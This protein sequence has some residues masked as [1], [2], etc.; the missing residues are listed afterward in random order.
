MPAKCISSIPMTGSMQASKQG[1]EADDDSS[2]PSPGGVLGGLLGGAKQVH[3]GFAPHSCKLSDALSVE[4]LP[5]R[6]C[7]SP[8]HAFYTRIGSS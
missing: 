2:P 4:P 5:Q 6:V 1:A 3:S 8:Q 7:H